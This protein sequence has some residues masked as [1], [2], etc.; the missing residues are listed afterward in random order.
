MDASFIANGRT[1]WSLCVQFT[2]IFWYVS[3]FLCVDIYTYVHVRTGNSIC[4]CSTTSF[5]TQWVRQLIYN[6]ILYT[7]IHILYYI[8]MYIHIL[9]TY[10]HTY[11]NIL[12]SFVRVNFKGRIVPYTSHT[13]V[14]SCSPHYIQHLLVKCCCLHSSCLLLV[15]FARAGNC[16]DRQRHLVVHGRRMTLWD[17]CLTAMLGQCVSVESKVCCA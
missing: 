15:C 2:E 11:V 6:I 10:I 5:S 3:M 12:N 17:A 1:L 13:Y 9:C 8:I 14:R 7:C 16:T 4:V